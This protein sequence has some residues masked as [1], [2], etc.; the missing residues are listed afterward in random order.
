MKETWFAFQLSVVALGALYACQGCAQRILV[1]GH[2]GDPEAA[3]ENT[4]ASFRGALGGQADY[5][6]LDTRVSADGTIYCLHDDT[7]DRTTD[8]VKQIGGQKIKFAQLTDRQIDA[9]DAGSWFDLKYAGE[10]IPRLTDALDLIQARSRTLLEWK[11]GSAESCARM[12]REKQLIGKLVVQSFDW[13]FLEELHKLEP[14][15]PLAVLGEKAFD[16][17]RWSGL[18]ATGARIVAWKH[19]DLDA[20][21]IARLHARGYQVFAWTVDELA[22]WQRLAATGVD[23]IITNRPGQLRQAIQ[24]GKL[25]HRSASAK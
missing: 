1:I 3:P 9:L 20:D 22:D 14:A 11:A 5:V 25:A 2:R 19:T 21:L 16:E 18:P 13:K 17:K 7:V 24:D 6:E 23:G 4:L 15:Q 10:R 12:L 8:A